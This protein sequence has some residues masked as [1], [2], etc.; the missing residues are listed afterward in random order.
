M[1]F[2]A[3]VLASVTDFVDGWVARKY[4]MQTRLGS[5]LDPLADKV[6]MTTVTATLATT[7][8][9]PAYLAVLIIGRDLMLSTAVAVFRYRTIPEPVHLNYSIN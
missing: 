8:L 7:P 3:F 5:L 2:G 6:L 4:N 1:A 9:M